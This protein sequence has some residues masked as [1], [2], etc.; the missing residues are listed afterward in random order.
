MGRS[1][2]GLSTKPHL[3]C[4]QGR[5]L[6]SVVVTGGWRG[7]APQ[8][9]AVM[10]AI[11]APRIGPGRLRTHP[12]LVRADKAYSSRAIRAHLRRRGIRATIPEPADRVLGRL[13]HG[14]RGGR[15]PVFD[16]ADY[17]DR[18]A[19]KYGINRLKRHRAV[20]TGMTS[21]PSAMRQATALISALNN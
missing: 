7:D 4:K 20:V 13:R 3:A 18:N 6:L 17:R 12:C 14:S 15:P 10:A 1:R 8:F 9:E 19:V 2:G 21:S 11:Q 5:R 16:R